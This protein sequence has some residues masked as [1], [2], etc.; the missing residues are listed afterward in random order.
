MGNPYIGTHRLLG[1]WARESTHLWVMG[2]WNDRT[3]WEIIE[4][5]AQPA[6][7]IQSE[8]GGGHWN[9]ARLRMGWRHTDILH[10]NIP[11]PGNQHSTGLNVLKLGELAG[12]GPWI[13]LPSWLYELGLIWALCDDNPKTYLRCKCDGMPSLRTDLFCMGGKRIYG[14]NARF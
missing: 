1:W 7:L 14:V 3:N 9:G 2:P 12:L 6:F 4:Y 8:S 10:L 5:I 13:D 11:T